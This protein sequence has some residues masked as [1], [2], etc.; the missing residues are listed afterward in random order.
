[1]KKGLL[2]LF[3]VL[4]VLTA[5]AQTGIDNDEWGAGFDASYIRG[6]TNLKKQISHPAVAISAVYD[7]Y[8]P[9][10]A[11]LQFGRL[12]GGGETPA[13]DLSGR[14]YSNNYIAFLLHGD[15]NLASVVDFQD[16]DFLNAIKGFYVG[17]GGG[18]IFNNNKVQRYNQ[19]P[20]NDPIGSTNGFQGK[21]KS[22]NPAVT[23]R[24]GYEFKFL[25]SYNQETMSLTI[26]YVHNFV[27]GEGLDGYN[28]PHP[29]FQN[30]H[31]NQYR[32]ITVGIRYYFIHNY[33]P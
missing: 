9:I 5:K 26:G 2:F 19:Y 21:D 29:P 10:V 31:T 23:L 33:M 25:D 6:F 24:A 30:L 18:L 14:Y 32:Q 13:T 28:D 11:E 16:S 12:S 20:W 8:M 15:F 3:A 1:M 7:A 22:V 4:A 17:T 27:F